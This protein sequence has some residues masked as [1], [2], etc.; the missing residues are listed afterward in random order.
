MRE[1][2]Y[3][4]DNNC[5][6]LKTAPLYRIKIIKAS[7]IFILLALM[8]SVSSCKPNRP[9]EIQ[10]LT[11]REELP[12]L[13]LHDLTATIT[14][15]GKIKYQFITPEMLQFDQRKEPTIEF[16]KGLH[17]FVYNNEQEVDAQIKSN[18]AIYYQDDDLWELRNDVE[19]VNTDGDV[20]NTELLFWDAQKEIIYSDQFIKITTDTEIITGYGFESDER[21][22]NYIIKNI[23]GI[24]Q[25]DDIQTG[26]ASADEPEEI[27]P[28]INQQRP[29]ISED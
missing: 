3:E 22:Q 15:S 23:S 17:L 7:S 24:L 13:I 6:H 18:E 5:A 26:T 16:P 14:D 19:A 11:N 28:E 21:M 25:V 27:A 2:Q 29:T 8:V 1:P 12:S 20:I 4:P 9:E 10:E